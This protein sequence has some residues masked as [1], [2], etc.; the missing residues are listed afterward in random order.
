[1]RVYFNAAELI[2]PF[3]ARSS[4]PVGSNVVVLTVSEKVKDSLFVRR[5]SAN[6]TSDGLVASAVKGFAAVL[7]ASPSGT[8][9]LPRLSAANVVDTA[10]TVLLADVASAVRALI[11]FR[12]AALS[13]IFTAL[14]SLYSVAF[15]PACSVYP[16]GSAELTSVT[17]V[18]LIESVTGSD[19][20]I[21]STPA[22]RS[23]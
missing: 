3:L 6:P 15:D 13:V 5:S 19:M 1:M 22:L 7:L 9:G 11:A 16:V 18:T 17:L 20:L 12:S 4:R 10:S 2:E 23:K 14:C 8:T 21:C